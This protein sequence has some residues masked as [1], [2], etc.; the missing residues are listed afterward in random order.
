MVG[1]MLL[2]NKEQVLWRGRGLGESSL[3]FLSSFFSSSEFFGFS[4]SPSHGKRTLNIGKNKHYK[5]DVTSF[6]RF[7]T[8][9]LLIVIVLVFNFFIL[10]RLVGAVG[11]WVWIWIRVALRGAAFVVAVTTALPLS[12]LTVIKNMKTFGLFQLLAGKYLQWWQQY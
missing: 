6:T 4:S 11:I 2:M 3:G 9:T 8:V 5:P 12:P 10:G 7:L 1:A